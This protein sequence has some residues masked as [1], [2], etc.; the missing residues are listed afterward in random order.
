MP[1]N[2]ALIEKQSLQ[3]HRMFVDVFDISMKGITTHPP[4]HPPTHPPTFLLPPTHPPHDHTYLLAFAYPPAYSE[5]VSLWEVGG[6][7]VGREARGWLGVPAKSTGAILSPEYVCLVIKKLNKK[8][9]SKT[10]QGHICNELMDNH[11]FEVEIITRSGRKG[12]IERA[13]A[14]FQK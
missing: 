10:N 3:K 13:G 6:R 4:I 9:R 2:L 7:G 11:C 8:C 1:K 12:C 5:E 14:H